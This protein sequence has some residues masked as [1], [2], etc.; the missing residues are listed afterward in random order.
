MRASDL[1]RGSLTNQFA[2]PMANAAS[3]PSLFGAPILVIM[4]AALAVIVPFIFLG[5]PSGHDFEFHMN[6]W[7]EVL[8]QWKHGV[9]YPG[10]GGL[11]HYGYGEPRFI[12]YPPASWTLGAILGA[13]L[14]WAIVPAAYT[15]IALTL[16][17]CT[18]FVFSRA[19]L[20][21]NDAIFAAVF[22]SVNPYYLV[23]I[24]WRSAFAEL[25]A[26]AL[27]P[28]LAILV[29][30]LPKGRRAVVP[31]AL[32]VAAVWLTNIPAA[33]MATYSLGL[34]VL[35]VAIEKRSPGIAGRGLLAVA[36]GLM[37][38]A[39]YV[40]PVIYEQKWINIAQVLAPGVRP[41]DNFLF[42][43]IHDPDHDRFNLLVS[44]VA[45][46]EITALAGTVFLLWRRKPSLPLWPYFALWCLATALIMFP[47]T[48]F[49]WKHF[50]ELEFVQLPWRWL[51]C[52]NVAFALLLPTAW[53]RW[54]T[55]I[56][57]YAVFLAMIAF[58]WHRVQQPW[59]DNA[60]DIAEMLDDQQTGQGYEGTDEYVPAGTDGYDISK[61]APLVTGENGIPVQIRIEK[62]DA[63]AKLFTAD[64]SLPSKLYLRLFNYPAWN[65][66]VNGNVTA[67]QTRPLTGQ[68]VI[69]I[70]A[71]MNR[72]SITFART[73]DRTIG[74]LISLLMAFL[75]TMFA[76]R[77]R[78]RR[79]LVTPIGVS[80]LNQ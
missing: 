8:T 24:Y 49:A 45:F 12:F 23:V 30:Q 40:L 73:W 76:W 6:S 79:S 77:Q 18:S 4:V 51:L 62:W 17:G 69:P 36:M 7:M 65:V 20:S 67:T 55:R 14:P 60:S 74:L 48:F 27:L 35:I 42:T 64:T 72:V 26:G 2:E 66:E 22:Y 80:R 13:L 9:I 78:C 1:K 11:A 59:W 10:W 33:V 21:R 68:M 52:F 34:L 58:V 41:A 25:L 50:P 38:A 19:W 5:N 39:F 47:F 63:Q 3:A 28:L 15:W 44:L 29:W 54:T 46:S 32:I 75:M 57:M 70:Q 16:S 37:L 56:L 53:R 61:D 43:N 31:L 71:G